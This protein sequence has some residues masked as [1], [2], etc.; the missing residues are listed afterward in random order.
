MRSKSL[1]KKYIVRL[2]SNLNTQVA[3]LT[4]RLNL[5]EKNDDT[6]EVYEEDLADDRL[7]INNDEVSV[8]CNSNIQ[9]VQ[10]TDLNK[11]SCVTKG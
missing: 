5:L 2:I 10:T 4:A 9:V 7:V 3:A 11:T 1:K 8:K 6:T